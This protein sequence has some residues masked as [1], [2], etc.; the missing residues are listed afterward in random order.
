MP[1]TPTRPSAGHPAPLLRLALAAA[2]CGLFGAC[3]R[4][5]PT[6]AKAPAREAVALLDGEPLSRDLI[7]EIARQQRGSL[8]PY[9]APVATAHAASAPPDPPE[10]RQRLLDELVEI[11]LLA[12]KARER[13]IDQQ[14]EVQAASELQTKTLLAQAMVREQIASIE[15]TDAELAAAYE[16]RVPPHLFKI[17][18]IVVPDAD[19]G[20]AL[21]QQLAQGRPFAELAQRHSLDADTR[22]K[23]GRIGSLMYDQMPPAIA[24]AVRH[25]KPGQHAPQPV[26]TEHGWHVV[27]LQGLEPLLE[28][29]TLQTARVW[30]HPQIVHA[31]VQAQQQQ[32]RREAQV[33]LAPSP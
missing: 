13:G 25:L 24:A 5:A 33:Q 1:L 11:E 12:R 22:K 21:L 26:Q 19:T 20:Q 29:P 9:D 17:A 8:N 15:V 28:R 30:L 32:W 6:E 10:H 2:L 16:E 23:G 27:Q 14:P 4:T 3:E 7:D 31:K 18:H